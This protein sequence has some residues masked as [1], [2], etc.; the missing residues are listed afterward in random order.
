MDEMVQ[1]EKEKRAVPGRR[2]FDLRESPFRGA[3]LAEDLLIWA[4]H[5]GAGDLHITVGKTPVLRVNGKLRELPELLAND[6]EPVKLIT[7]EL[8][9]V[10][11]SLNGPVTP[12][13]A[14]EVALSLLR[15]KRHSET[16]RAKGNV[17][18]ACSIPGLSRFRVNMYRQRGSYAVA[19]RVLADRV[20]NLQELFP[21]SPGW[22][23]AIRK[24]ASL[25][26]GLVLVTG[27]TGS[28]KST[29]LAAMVDYINSNCKKH[30]ITL[31]DPIEYLHRHKLGMVNQREVGEDVESF[32]EGLRS[33]LREDPDVIMVGEMRDLETIAT[34]I[35]AAETGHLVLSTLHTNTAPETVE[36][37]IDVFPPYQQQ[38]IRVQLAGVLRGVVCQQLIAR[39]DEQG[40]VC[41]L[42]ILV[43]T[44][45]VRALIR[46][47][48]THQLSSVI[49]T[50][51][52][53]GMVPMERS[54]AEMVSAGLIARE[55][56]FDR[57]Y[58]P[59]LLARYLER[60]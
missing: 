57:A 1:E 12:H 4:V 48:K 47:N 44:Q 35:T 55:A 24:L 58:D 38:Q 19:C 8:L 43:G 50:G 41:A 40:L 33:A 23:A 59:R 5:C 37:I 60:K 34:A 2:P 21:Y 52:Q 22:V 17:D 29:T 54:L 28:G 56:A 32:A 46:E 31:E 11:P 25:N 3:S 51:F 36:R 26:R 18:I 39:K 15:D 42:E 9:R 6:C 10:W 14:E 20:P 7:E 27:P 53:E 13:Q 16:L 49:Q 45:A 30:I